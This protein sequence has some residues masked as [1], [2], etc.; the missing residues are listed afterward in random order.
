MITE[1]RTHYSKFTEALCIE[2]GNGNGYGT[3][4]LVPGVLKD[5]TAIRL[6]SLTPGKLNQVIGLLRSVLRLVEQGASSQYPFEVLV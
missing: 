2:R 6:S 5:A 1:L 3:S 4:L